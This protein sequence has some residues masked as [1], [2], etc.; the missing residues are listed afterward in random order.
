VVNKG[1]PGF[2]Y[3]AGSYTGTY[4]GTLAGPTITVTG[5]AALYAAPTGTFTLAAATSQIGGNVYRQWGRHLWRAPAS[6]FA[7][8]VFDPH[9][10]FSQ[11]LGRRQLSGPRHPD[12]TK[13]IT[14]SKATATYNPHRDS[15]G[16]AGFN[17]PIAF[18]QFFILKGITK[19]A[20]SIRCTALSM[21]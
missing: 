4:G 18:T 3:S 6:D 17:A 16:T 2:T 14:L 1:T 8:R 15:V 7:E 12:G 20:K 19:K 13:S 10:P 9:S 21:Q 11:L 5:S